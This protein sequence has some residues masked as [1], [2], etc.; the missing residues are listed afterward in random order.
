MNIF[1]THSQRARLLMAAFAAQAGIAL[2]QFTT[3]H[4]TSIPGDVTNSLART[5]FI[6]HGLVAVGHISGSTLDT[7]GETFGSISS[8][9]V[10]GWTNR[11]DGSYGGVINILPDRGYNSGNFYSDFAARINQV[12]FTF[13]PYYGTTNI[14]GTTDLEKLDA[15]TNHLSFG[16]LTG[17]KFTYD[18]PYTGSNSFTTGLDPGTNFA[19][20]FG[21][22]MPYVSTFIGFP[23]PA[24]TNNTIFT[25]I[26]K[27]PIDAEALM[28]RPDG[29]GYIGDE[30]GAHVYYYD[31]TKKIVGA[32]APPPAMQPH[33]PTNVLNYSSVSAPLNGRR[34]N[35]GFE[36]VSLSPDGT[37]IFA[38]MQSACMQ[39]SQAANNQNAKNTR[40]LIYD[41]SANPTN[42]TPIAEYALTLP[43]Y[44]LNGNGGPAD[45]TC[46]QSE[47]VALDNKRFLVLSRDGNGLGNSAP[48]PNMYKS[49]LLVDISAGGP[50]SFV[51]DAARNAEGGTITSNGVPGVLDPAIKPLQWVEAVNLLNTN[52]LAKFNIQY[53]NGSN[54]VTKLF[55]GE[56]WEGMSLVS[57]GDPARP[58]DYFLFVGND[59]DF[60]T[61]N[62]HMR[63]PDGNMITYNAFNGYPT[64]R[65]PAALDTP[66]NENDTRILVFRVTITTGF[67]SG[68]LVIERMGDGTAALGNTGT[69]VFIDEYSATGEWLQSKAMPRAVSRP[70]AAP[71][72]L[73]DSG[74]ATSN[75]QL[76]RSADGRFICIPGY[77]GTNG[78]TGIAGSS[79]ATVLRV[80]G[81]IDP[82]GNVD[83]SRAASFLSGNNYRSLASTD[84]SSFW[85]AGAPGLVYYEPGVTNSL[86]AGNLRCVKIINNQLFISSGSATPGVGVH[87][88]GSGVP[89]N[90][91]QTTTQLISVGGS[92][93]SPYQFEFNSDMTVAYVADDRNN[94]SGGIIK[95]TNSGTAWV[96]NYT[97]TTISNANVG[98]RGLVVDWS[99]SAPL[100]YATTAEAS[101]NRII[102]ILDTNSA[103]VAVTLATA[104]TNTAFRSV[105]FAPVSSER[106]TI[107][108]K[109]VLQDGTFQI[110]FSARSGQRFAVT[111]SDTLAQPVMNWT[112]LSNG[113]FGAAPSTFTDTNAPAAVKRFYEIVSP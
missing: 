108:G 62:G 72:N 39:D 80:M 46:A 105:A 98:A 69:P 102:R 52:Q 11:G 18:D 64:N 25:N 24:N 107:L 104:P 113:V 109:T 12:E 87:A 70:A 21:Q 57:V 47:V 9:Q 63:G 86:F 68:N 29:S 65:I 71:F 6:N 58:D 19:T 99:G 55:M 106:P 1:A 101:T 56:K 84:G 83:T 42:S 37:R 10:T 43:T 30:Y 82:A 45:R 4:V 110:T 97:L 91:T 112:V 74:S 78:E 88:V 93:P 66:N 27:L 54:Q 20:L 44:K 14:G 5:T 23:T 38:L 17:V 35:Q 100:I 61:S 40:L 32:I 111:A 51:N 90:G 3:P 94:A 13:R 89:T 75:G 16:A 8:M 59:N 103:A 28:L 31:S 79:G 76:T 53:D 92:S 26:N 73:M 60:L 96:S 95:Y 34:N 77:N 81:T 67:S 85:A 7:F 41:V 22:P 36:G 48:N 49:I 15:Q 33:L 2:A 50:T